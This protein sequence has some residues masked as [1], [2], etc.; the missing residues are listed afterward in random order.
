M[1]MHEKPHRFLPQSIKCFGQARQI[2]ACRRHSGLQSIEKASTGVK[3]THV[4][5]CRQAG[6]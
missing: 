6:P 4:R 1:T 2:K 5:V 3:K